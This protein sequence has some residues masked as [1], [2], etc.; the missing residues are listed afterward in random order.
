MIFSL[1]RKYVVMAVAIPLAAAAAHKLSEVIEARRGPSRITRMLR[2][3]SDIL[4]GGTLGR[5]KKRRRFAF[6]R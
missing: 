6:G 5:Q 1:I 4:R 2:Q 3:A